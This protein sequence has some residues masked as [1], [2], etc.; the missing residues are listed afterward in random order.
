MHYKLV[1]RAS[2]SE[3][4]FT[5]YSDASHVSGAAVGWSSKRQPF[6]TLSSTEAEFVAAVEAWQ[7]DQVD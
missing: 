4:L 3:E 2:D 7:G 5:T 6:V 1:Y